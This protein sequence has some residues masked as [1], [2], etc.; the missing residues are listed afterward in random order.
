[1]TRMLIDTSSVSWTGLLAGKDEENGREVEYEEKKV[2]I[3]SA[4]FGYEK[5]MDYIIEAMTYVNLVPSQLVFVVEGKM[6][7]ERRVSL[8]NRYKA[9]RNSRPPEA[10][11]E[12]NKMVSMVTAAFRSVGACSVVNDG[13]EGDDVLAY[14]CE[15]LD[16]KKIILTNDGDMAALL[17]PDVTMIRKGE[18]IEDN[19]IGPFNV[20]FIRLYK[21]LVGDSSDNIKGAPGFGEKAWLD[22]LVAYGDLGCAAVEGLIK[23]QALHELEDDVGEFKAFRKVIDGAES[24]YKSWDVAGLYPEWCDTKRQPLVVTD[25]VIAPIEDERLE[26]WKNWGVSKL[27]AEI[28]PAPKPK[29]HAVFDIEIMGKDK[30]VFLLCAKIVETGERFAFW[31]HN[32]GDMAMLGEM[33]KRDDLT[34]V[35]FN[36]INFDAPLLSAA[37]AGKDPVVLKQMATEIINENAKAWMLPERF[38]YDNVEFDH[39]DLIEVAPGVRISLKTYA[40]RM[41]YPTMVDLPFHHDEDLSGDQLQ[42]VEDYCFNDLGVTE[43]LFKRLRSEIN[44]RAEMSR[45]YDVDL[46]S[47]SDAQIAEAALRKVLGITGKVE[48]NPPSHVTYRAPDFIQT[49]SPEI[50]ALIEKLHETQFKINHANGSPENPA[51]LKDE[52]LKIG[53]GTYQCGIGGLHST[54]DKRFHIEATE[55]MDVCDFDVASYYPSLILKSGL[56]PKMGGKGTKFIQEYTKFYQKRLEAKKA[57]NKRVSNSLKTVLNGSFGKL[58]NL[59]SALYSPDLLLAVT[60]TGQLNLLCL[61]H[62]L[63]KLPSVCVTS[64]NTDGIMVSYPKRRRDQVL[65]VI[66]DNAASTG[67]DYEETKY[68]AVAMKDVNNYAAI[69]TDGQVKAKGLYASNRPEE[70]SL[71]LMK[72]PTMEA[73]SRM[74]I[75]YIKDGVHPSDSIAKYTDIRDFVAIRNVKGGGVVYSGIEEVDDWVEVEEGQWRR[76]AW[77]DNGIDRASVKRKSRP[78]P[79]EVG[80]GGQSFGRV[81]RWY[82]TTDNVQPLCYSGSG[83]K[84]PKTDGA[85]LCLNLPD[86]LPSDL[87]KQWYVDE[88]LSMLADMGVQVDVEV[89]EKI[90][91]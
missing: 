28:H 50:N 60:I 71:Y 29:N 87:N 20:K 1:M 84:V 14:L 18:L 56:S 55:N 24:V 33:I 42:V 78:K 88:A 52:P 37:L 65:A 30:P 17:G 86:E 58:G 49:D 69:T 22:M 51:W 38:K 83:N 72:N 34:W 40:G 61:I 80:T 15:K 62:E 63:E 67:F 43:E 39:I 12:F 85:K 73:C 8:D 26:P 66:A 57:G 70:N 64:A 54:H 45:D 16:G 48:V 27:E 74:A 9:T 3:N 25:G 81:A 10:Y 76:Q 47:K 23:R 82:M 77:I 59:Y 2:W 32:G 19:P 11:E 68:R 13:V 53:N 75:E 36:G 79:V 90:A 41:A 7:K 6:S 89:Q 4:D 91:A 31:W 5:V 35:S 44:L 46:R 21:T